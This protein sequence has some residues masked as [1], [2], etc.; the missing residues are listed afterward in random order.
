[1]LAP[2]K[3]MVNPGKISDHNILVEIEWDGNRLS[4]CGTI[5]STDD[6]G[7]SVGWQI[8]DD[9][10]RLQN[11]IQYHPG[12][13]RDVMEKFLDIWYQWHLNDLR[14]G[15]RHQRDLGWHKM[16][17]DPQK[18]LDAYGKHFDG[19]VTPT[20]NMLAWVTRREHPSGLLLEPCPVCGYKYGSAWL[21]ED[22]PEDVLQWLY[23]LPEFTR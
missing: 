15:C 7:S 20:W 10:K 6:D 11:S 8:Q 9:L 14:A 12:W 3:K 21:K 1:M 22:V 13:D 16:P 19:Q 5:T 23:A 18:P 2:F 17:I 4:M